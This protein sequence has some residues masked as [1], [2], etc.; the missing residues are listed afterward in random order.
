[1]K[2]IL[3]HID[4]FPARIVTPA[5]TFERARLVVQAGRAYVWEEQAGGVVP[6]V[7]QS[8]AVLERDR[9]AAA[10]Y[11]VVTASGEVWE[12]KKSG[13][14]GC[15]SPLKRLDWRAQLVTLQESAT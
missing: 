4:L 8:D 2:Q 7:L 1:M 14:C 5:K 13:G 12:C 11:Q 10:P 3:E 9:S 6:L 15:G